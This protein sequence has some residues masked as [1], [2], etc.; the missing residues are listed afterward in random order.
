VN[1]ADQSFTAI[2]DGSTL[3]YP[4]DL[5]PIST[6]GWCFV[7]HN[8][9]LLVGGSF[10]DMQSMKGVAQWNIDTWIATPYSVGNALPVVK[11]FSNNDTLIVSGSFTTPY[12]GLAMHD[13]TLWHPMGGMLNGMA[14]DFATY[15]GS[16]YA[17]GW[18]TLSGTTPLNRVARWTGSAWEDVGGGVNAIAYDMEVYNGELYVAGAFSTAGGLSVGGIAKWNGSSWSTLDNGSPLPGSQHIHALA[19]TSQGLYVGGYFTN[20]NGMP[21]QNVAIWNGTNWSDPGGLPDL[22]QSVYCIVEHLGHIYLGTGHSGLS[23]NYGLL[24]RDS[25]VGMEEPLQQQVFIGPNPVQHTLTVR[26]PNA[27][28]RTLTLYDAQGRKLRSVTGSNTMPMADLAAGTYVLRTDLEK[29]VTTHRVV[30]DE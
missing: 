13:G 25:G 21:F 6:E 4:N 12:P 8:N 3:N 19:V 9:A 27:P 24:W 5:P 16:L 20:L 2:F 11:M 7:E 28:I 30:K 23:N 14:L 22:D 18:F 29:G 15:D 10:A 26:S 1:G 17:C